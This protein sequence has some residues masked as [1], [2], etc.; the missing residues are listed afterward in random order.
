VTSWEPQARSLVL[1]A[2][3]GVP[4]RVFGNP[5]LLKVSGAESHGA[6]ALLSGSFASGTGAIP[7]LHRGHDEIFY[8][9][10]GRFRFHLGDELVEAGAGALLFAPRNAPH[11]FTNIGDAP[12]SLLGIVAPAGY[13]QHFV[14]ISAVP[15]GPDARE[16]LAEIY[17]KYDQEPV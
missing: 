6:V 1:P 11:G 4:L 7:H 9:L 16:V 15:D 10:D 17:R 14:D 13:E 12:G 5:F 3:S 2:D 8:V